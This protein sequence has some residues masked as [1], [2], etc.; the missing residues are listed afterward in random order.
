MGRWNQEIHEEEERRAKLAKPP[1]LVN[2]S[3]LARTTEE[4]EESE[5]ESESESE[6]FGSESEDDG[7]SD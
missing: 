1:N 5:A 4:S 3:K 7:D 2:S 6:D